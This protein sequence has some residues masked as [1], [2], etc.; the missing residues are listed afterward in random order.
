MFVAVCVTQQFHDDVSV[1]LAV[2]ERVSKQLAHRQE[3]NTNLTQ[4]ISDRLSRLHAAMMDLRD[5]LNEAVNNTATAAEINNANE[6]TLEDNKVRA[7]ERG[8]GSHGTMDR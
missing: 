8:T 3:E 4:S 1:C 6:K 2:L 7:A 5:A